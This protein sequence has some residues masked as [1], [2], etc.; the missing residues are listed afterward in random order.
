MEKVVTKLNGLL[1]S[2]RK[3]EIVME[4]EDRRAR[5]NLEVLLGPDGTAH[6]ASAGHN[7]DH[8]HQQA[9]VSGPACLR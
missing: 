2:G 9:K 4:C 8:L 1:L 6:V 3:A 7:Q 5:V